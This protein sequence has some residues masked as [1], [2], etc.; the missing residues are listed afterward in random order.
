MQ[1]IIK[2]IIAITFLT[3]G[4]LSFAQEGDFTIEFAQQNPDSK[5]TGVID[6]FVKI[7]NNTN[8][9]LTGEFEVHSN[10]EDLYLVQR[11]PKTVSLTANDSIFIPVKAIISRTAKAGNQPSIEAV[12]TTNN[13][14]TKS[15]TLPITITERKLV[16]MFLLETNLIYENIGDTLT[17]PIRI[18][19]DG[20]TEQKIDIV[21]RYPNFIAKDMMETNSIKINA[22]TDTL[23][24]LKKQVTKHIMA[25]EDF[26]LTITSLYQSGDIIGI[27]NIR[28]SSIKQDRR[29][30]TQFNP[31][32]AQTFNQT[33]QITVSHLENSS[34]A[35]AYYFYANAEA[36]IN[37]SKIYTNIDAN[38]WTNSNQLFLRN[39]WLGYK[40]SDFGIQAGNVSKFADINL[41]GRGAQAYYSTSKDSKIEVGGIDKS[42]NLADYSNP[43]GGTSAWASYFHNGGWLDRGF[44]SNL[45]YDHDKFTGI[46]SLLATSKFSVLKKQNFSLKA[47]GGLSNANYEAAN[48]NKAGAAGEIVAVGKKGNLYYSSTNFVSNGYY[49]GVK[50]GV[51]NFNERVNWTT[52]KY[53]MWVVYNYMSVKPKSLTEQVLYSTL[54]RT[55]RYNIGGSRRFSNITLSVSP[56]VYSEKRDEPLYVG[57]SQTRSMDAYRMNIGI[58]YSNHISTVN[59][60]L[61]GG[62]FKTNIENQPSQFHIKANL[63]YSWKFLNLLTTYQYNSF[64]LGEAIANYQTNPDKTFY[65][66]MINPSAVLKFFDNKLILYTGATFASNTINERITQLNGRADYKI[67]PDFNL[68]VNGYYSDISNNPYSLNSFQVGLTKQF[69]PIRIDSSKSD[70]EV[71]VYYENESKGAE[72]IP[73]ANQLIIISGKAFRTNNQGIIKYR[74]LPPGDYEIRP[75]NSNEWHAYNR[76]VNV[77]QDTQVSIGLTKTSTIKGS[78]S[79]TQTERSYEITKKL[80]GLSIIAVDDTG[81]IFQSR[82][83][84]VGNF[85]LYVPKGN[86][87][88]TLEK[89]GVSEY[90]D[91]EH[92]NRNIQAIPDTITEVKFNLN[93]KEKRVE[94]RKFS[95]RGFPSQSSGNKKKKKK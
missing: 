71:Y 43:S 7:K 14:N 31:D 89:S 83:D 77:I 50:R 75:V 44:E 86:Y 85:I 38:L 27:A 62:S 25:Q 51:L 18:S 19:N 80:G 24:Y 53:N 20:N 15:V 91:I 94:T 92:N 72:N 82:T 45:I 13:N 32:Y 49:A 6:A 35:S 79:Y 73:A 52:E 63:I 57:G 81:N 40:N 10:H 46:N 5:N 88:I 95:S 65:N 41:V 58:N 1:G 2:Y 59:F 33:N 21:T 42:Y 64:N 9:N 11:K 60:I 12:F 23:V 84:D 61:D 4:N 90:V 39:T 28:A 76:T 87:T 67:S 66:I 30:T 16:K 74:S 69:R 68:F 48:T 8:N 22:F 70:L 36:Q 26:N 55:S 37:K 17:I 34:N 54:F 78:I 3:I 47:G 93:I 29:Y 56:N